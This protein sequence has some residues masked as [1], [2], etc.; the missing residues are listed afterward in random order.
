MEALDNLSLE[1]NLRAE[2]C[3]LMLQTLNKAPPEFLPTIVGF[4]ISSEE[5]FENLVEVGLWR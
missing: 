5:P 3:K 2:V 4:L 1:N